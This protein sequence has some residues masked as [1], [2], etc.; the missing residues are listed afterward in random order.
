MTRA[1][2]VRAVRV[3]PVVAAG[4]GLVL[5][6]AAT[7]ASA[8]TDDA[9]GRVLRGLPPGLAA[10]VPAD[11]TAGAVWAPGERLVYV[12]TMGS[13]SCPTIAEPKARNTKAGVGL[14]RASEV[15]DVDATLRESDQDAPCTT[16]WTPTTTVIEAPEGKDHGD[17]V[18]V[19]IGGLGTVEL[20]PREKNDQVGQPSWIRG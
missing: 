19:R 6:A 18:S 13:S 4:A 3:I 1:H 20:F 7:A 5:L 16:D 2:R 11:A 15:A 12:V 9:P 14:A 17:P 8:T 10:D